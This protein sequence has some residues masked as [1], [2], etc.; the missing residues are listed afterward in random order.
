MKNPTLPSPSGQQ[1]LSKNVYF[2]DDAGNEIR[3]IYQRNN[4]TG[5]SSYRLYPDGGNTKAADMDVQDYRELA[6]HL[7]SGC[8]VRCRVST[9]DSSN[10]SIDSKD[11][12]KLVIEIER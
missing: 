1:Q 12:R 10:R 6:K 9:G 8:S 5:K 7:L 4:D 2:V 3:P 11:I